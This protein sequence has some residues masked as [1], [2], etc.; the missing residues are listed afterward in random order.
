M[1]AIQ[2][3]GALAAQEVGGL[4][5]PGPSPDPRI[6]GGAGTIAPMPSPGEPFPPAGIF[7]DAH[8]M[9]SRGRGG[10]GGA[11][12]HA[13]GAGHG[14]AEQGGYGREGL[15]AAPGSGSTPIGAPR[16]SRTPDSHLLQQQQQQRHVGWAPSGGRLDALRPA[17]LELALAASSPLGAGGG[18]AGAAGASGS[19]VMMLPGRG[20]AKRIPLL[21]LKTRLGALRAVRQQRRPRRPPPSEFQELLRNCFGLLSA[22]AL[23]SSGCRAICEVPRPAA[24]EGG[25]EGGAEAVGGILPFAAAL[26]ET[27]A[28][29]PESLAAAAVSG[30]STELRCVCA[31]GRLCVWPSTPVVHVCAFGRAPQSYASVRLAEHPSRT[32]CKALKMEALSVPNIATHIQQVFFS[33]MDICVMPCC[34]CSHRLQLFALMGNIALHS[35]G[36]EA[37]T[38]EAAGA[39]PGLVAALFAAARES[40]ALVG[41]SP[42]GWREG[43]R[44]LEVRCGATGLV[45]HSC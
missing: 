33:R 11:E 45:R 37:L 31:C 24:G 19:A 30:S 41:S 10:A 15:P 6:S 28:D 36:V 2:A 18:A 12:A 38:S 40:L 9:G 17:A 21:T 13:T 7:G 34:L 20:A 29:A 8:G 25:A 43:Q 16:S 1:Q 35:D 4:S 22:V 39:P 14:S 5:G 44:L 23:S 32:P 42:T 27:A 3:A 26:L